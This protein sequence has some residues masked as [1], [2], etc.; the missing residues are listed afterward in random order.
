MREGPQPCLGDVSHLENDPETTFAILKSSPSTYERMTFYVLHFAEN[1]IELD[2]VSFP[3][4]QKRNREKTGV[5]GF[6]T[7]KQCVREGAAEAAAWLV[8]HAG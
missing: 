1:Y 4:G 3:K 6:P 7:E 2:T 8:E 5:S